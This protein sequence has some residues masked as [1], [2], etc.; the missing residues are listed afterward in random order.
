MNKMNPQ[1]CAIVMGPN[2]L[3]PQTSANPMEALMVSQKAV[4][5]LDHLVSA[6]VRGREGT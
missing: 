3:R 2:L 1:N 5:F 4:L 6:E